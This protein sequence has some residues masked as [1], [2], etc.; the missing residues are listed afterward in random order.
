MHCD[1]AFTFD[2]RLLQLF[3]SNICLTTFLSLV[4]SPIQY[5]NEAERDFGRSFIANL[6]LIYLSCTSRLLLTTFIA[7][8]ISASVSRF[9]DIKLLNLVNILVLLHYT[10]SH[11]YTTILGTFLLATSH[12]L[13]SRSLSLRGYSMVNRTYRHM[14]SS[15]RC[16]RCW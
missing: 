3:S 9:L 10:L 12:F 1:S 7:C 6:T 8:F 13:G 5:Q 4:C 2:N 11:R 14:L 16:R 15:G